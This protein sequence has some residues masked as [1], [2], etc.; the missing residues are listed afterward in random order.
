LEYLLDSGSITSELT[1]F[2][3]G[4]FKLSTATSSLKAGSTTD[5]ADTAATNLQRRNFYFIR[6][7]GLGPLRAG[8]EAAASEYI[9]YY[10]D[11]VEKFDKKSQI[12]LIT[13]ILILVLSLFLLIPIT[14][15]V[16]KANNRVMSLFAF[17]PQSE[18]NE[19][20]V[21]CEIFIETFLQE[22]K[23]NRNF[24]QDSEE[25]EDGDNTNMGEEHGAY[26][27]KDD[28][29]VSRIHSYAEVNK[30]EI[31]E[32]DNLKGNTTYDPPK[33]EDVMGADEKSF[34]SSK[35]GVGL[36]VPEPLE[37]E[38]IPN[39]LANV[40]KMSDK[41]ARNGEPIDAKDKIKG[42]KAED[43]TKL[44]DA[45]KKAEHERIEGSSKTRRDGI[46]DHDMLLERSNQLLRARDSNRS[47][48]VIQFAIINLFFLGY[49]LGSYFQAHQFVINFEDT[50]HHFNLTSQR[51][52][53]IKLIYAFTLE[54]IAQVDLNT[55]YL[56]DGKT[57][58]LAFIIGIGVFKNYRTMY[59]NYLQENEKAIVNNIKKNFPSSFKDYISKFIT[60]NQQ[61]VCIAHYTDLADRASNFLL[62][63]CSQI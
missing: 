4:V 54:E 40:K 8:S 27:R 30:S 20:I 2:T 22:V 13:S 15:A 32:L 53:T 46:L 9:D 14:F 34:L 49:F 7:N 50:M 1:S 57:Y 45:K 44:M 59:V 60:Y 3:D 55:V 48:T 16:L 33:D 24:L 41:G 63:T 37:K 11:E 58:F 52:P 25:E 62:E 18:I 19:L 47:K 26:Q 21:K 38:K 10:T 39:P 12:I 6:R 35:S 51:I 31:T 42:V 28:M 36:Q 43:L 23:Q 17:I 61:D 56:Y 29:D 5:L